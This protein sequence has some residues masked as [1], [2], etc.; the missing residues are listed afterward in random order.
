L[1]HFGS[2]TRSEQDDS[3]PRANLKENS[4]AMPAQPQWTAGRRA[5]IHR[6]PYVRRALPDNPLSVR[7]GHEL[8]RSIR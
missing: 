4:D 1:A 2:Y 3:K 7:I 5:S 8:H 6:V